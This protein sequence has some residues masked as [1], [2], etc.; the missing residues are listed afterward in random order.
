M[1]YQQ[2]QGVY[3]AVADGMAVVLHPQDGQ[4]IVLNEAGAVIWQLVQKQLSI[5]GIVQQ[6]TAVYHAPAPDT[7]TDITA[8]INE[9]FTQGLLDAAD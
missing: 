6:F 4:T 8:F 9:L 1:K 7:L 2:K 3:S 5:A